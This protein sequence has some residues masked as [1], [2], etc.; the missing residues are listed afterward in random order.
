[1]DDDE[2]NFEALQQQHRRAWLY[3]CICFFMFAKLLLICW[4][5]SSS[6]P[7]IL[8]AMWDGMLGTNF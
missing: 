4:V 2:E 8:Y 6:V 1:M 5:L 3:G 7:S